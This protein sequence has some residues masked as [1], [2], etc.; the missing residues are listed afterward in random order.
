MRPRPDRRL[1]TALPDDR[2]GGGAEG[3]RPKR[4]SI[5]FWIVKR[6]AVSFL[7]MSLLSLVGVGYMVHREQTLTEEALRGLDAVAES[8][9]Q[10][11]KDAAAETLRG[12][13]TKLDRLSARTGDYSERVKGVLGRIRRESEGLYREAREAIGGPPLDGSCPETEAPSANRAPPE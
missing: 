7:V 5:L 12:L 13:R 11:D 1:E 6:L 8:L 3:V 10:N 4:R 2:T 9:E